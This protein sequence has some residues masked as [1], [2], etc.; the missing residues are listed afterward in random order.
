MTSTAS[1]ELQNCT[2]VDLFCGVGGLTYGLQN[3]G[4]NVSAGIDVDPECRFPYEFNNDSKFIEK[5][6]TRIKGED[7]QLIYP[8]GHIKVLVGCAPCQDFSKLSRAKRAA[9]SDKWSLLRHFERLIH[10]LHPDIISMENVP[11]IVQHEVYNEFIR[12]L[13]KLSYKYSSS[14]VHCPAYGVAQNRDRFV[15]FASLWAPISIIPPV[16]ENEDYPTVKDVLI[17]LEKLD[18]GGTSPTDPMHRCSKLSQLNLQRIR[19]SKPGGTWRDWPR[20]L[21]CACHQKESGETYPSVY[22]RMEWGAQAPTITTQY[23]GYG[24]GRFGH[25]EEDRA[26]SLREGALLQS[27][28]RNYQFVEPG[29]PIVL[30][31]VGRLIGNA[32]PPLLGEVVGRTIKVHVEALRP[33]VGYEKNIKNRRPNAKQASRS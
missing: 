1:S 11:E 13:D 21:R 9:K 17:N 16:L 6:V 33:S 27:F 10:E 3:A 28:P 29:K 32:V 22:G 24:N 23:F 15:L 4:I 8:Q 20:D 30:G 2:A 12:T 5:D 14:V 19:L 25:P 7:L 18:A 31:A 26:I